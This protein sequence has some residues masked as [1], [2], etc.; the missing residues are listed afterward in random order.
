MAKKRKPPE[1]KP[2]SRYWHTDECPT[3]GG[4]GRVRPASVLPGWYVS[5]QYQDGHETHG[6][7]SKDEAV[8]L[9]VG[10]DDRT[11]IGPDWLVYSVG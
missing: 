4:S 2:T 9:V 6:P 3:C 11:L 10:Y 8:R 5:Y 7:Y 1:P